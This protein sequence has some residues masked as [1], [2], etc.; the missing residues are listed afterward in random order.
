MVNNT[1]NI[2]QYTAQLHQRVLCDREIR[3]L[4]GTRGRSVVQMC[5][6]REFSVLDPLGCGIVAGR[7]RPLLGDWNRLKNERE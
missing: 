1:P 4:D 3:F 2:Q 7:L 6:Q 5:P